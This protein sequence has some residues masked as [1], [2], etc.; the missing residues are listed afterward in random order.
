MFLI[1]SR[2]REVSIAAKPT[3]SEDHPAKQDDPQASLRA[4]LLGQLVAAQFEIETVIA[5]LARDGAPASTM[6]DSR[7]QLA[8]L[9]ALR[10]Q[11]TGAD[12][13]ALVAM[14]SDIAATVAASQSTA[15]QART[16]AEASNTGSLANYAQNAR[17]A[18]NDVMRGMK[19][20]EPYL[21]FANAK[22][23]ADYRRREEERRAYIAAEQ[24]KGTPVGDLNASGAAVGQMADA[25]AH[26]AAESPEFQSRFN[27]LAQ[28]TQ[29]LRDQLIR[30]GKDVSQFDTHL[31]ED[32][33]TI[34][35]AK[36]VPDTKIDALLAAHPDN[37]L[38]AVKA[39]VAEQKGVIGEKELGDLSRKAQ[40]YKDSAEEKPA[41][42]QSPAP[43]S[44]MVDAMAKLKASGV[45]VAGDAPEQPVH[46]VT[47]Q[48]G[49][50][51]PSRSV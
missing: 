18:V 42:V 35:R 9:G 13:K 38:E 2:I 39:F 33:R 26:G 34:M 44:P 5:D 43:A 17:A 48:A 22:D 27:R 1:C 14:R 30:D 28:S 41:V 7:N 10:Q 47:T 20:F 37:P 4:E 45:M 8:A 24:A 36:G 12:V 15:Q 46:G 49:I 31:R 16:A 3:V 29:A 51:A 25:A 6:M 32:L 19:D 50:T 23:E 40:E 11:L 21:H